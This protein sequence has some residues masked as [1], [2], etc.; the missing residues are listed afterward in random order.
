MIHYAVILRYGVVAAFALTLG[1]SALAPANA[2]TGML[3]T[4]VQLAQTTPLR[5][6]NQNT[7]KCLAACSQRAQSCYR[8]AKGRAKEDCEN[9]EMSCKNRCR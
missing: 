9:G 3:G 4:P 8:A 6:G 1:V 5:M 7:Q 2:E